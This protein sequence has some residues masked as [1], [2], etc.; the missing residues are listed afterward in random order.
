MPEVMAALLSDGSDDS[1]TVRAALA[2]IDECDREL[3]RFPVDVPGVPLAA[4]SAASAASPAL[5]KP[6]KN[7]SRDKQKLEKLALRAQ[8]AEL[9]DQLMQ[10]QRSKGVKWRPGSGGSNGEGAGGASNAQL[11]QLWREVALRHQRRRREAGE[12]NSELRAAISRQL[13][14]IQLMRKILVRQAVDVSVS[15]CWLICGW[16]D[17]ECLARA[18]TPAT[19]G[20]A[21]AAAALSRRLRAA[22][23]RRGRAAGVSLAAYERWEP[24]RAIAG[25]AAAP[26]H[27]DAASVAHPDAHDA[28]GESLHPVRCCCGRKC[29]LGKRR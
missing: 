2:F 25:P 21:T 12:E 22:S 29:A 23:G 16:M 27:K 10:L 9:S 3:A 5:G 15:T 14:V 18:T 8:V 17:A 7:P 11:C 26:A 1:A 19:A 13:Q 24:T 6:R 28:G 4:P 20:R